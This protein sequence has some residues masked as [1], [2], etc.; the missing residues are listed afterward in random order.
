MTIQEQ[1]NLAQNRYNT[2]SHK[3]QN[4]KCGGVLKRLART[5]RN[6]KKRLPSS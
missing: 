5:I 1:L 2:L 4:I 3:P 6:L